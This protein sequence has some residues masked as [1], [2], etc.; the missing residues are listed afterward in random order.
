MGAGMSV[1][2][3]PA[4]EE[5]GTGASEQTD[6]MPSGDEAAALGTPEVMKNLKNYYLIPDHALNEPLHPTTT[7]TTRKN[8]PV[9]NF[10]EMNHFKKKELKDVVNLTNSEVHLNSSTM[11]AA[12]F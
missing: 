11:T 8:G 5:S 10:A 2:A 12:C 4:A 1:E 7:R 9:E 3:S 6:G